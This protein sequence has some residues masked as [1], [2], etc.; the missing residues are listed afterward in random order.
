MITQL[1]I[2]PLLQIGCTRPADLPTPAPIVD[3]VTSATP[4][5]IPSGPP[6]ADWDRDVLS[7]ELE[8]D[9]LSHLA[10]ARITFAG[11]TSTSASLDVYDLDVIEITGPDGPISY[12]RRSDRLDLE[13]PSGE[14]PVTVSIRYAFDNQNN[15]V[16]WMPELGVTYLFPDNCGYFYPCRPD[17]AEGST[18]SLDVVGTGD[19]VAVYPEEI[20][21]DAPS[22]MLGMALGDYQQI[23]LGT[24]TAG[25]EVS[26]WHLPGSRDRML[27][28]AGALV[29][30]FD[31]YEQTYG[32]YMFGHRVASVEASW[33]G[34]Y[35][36]AE[37]HPYWHVS[38]SA[39]PDPEVHAHEAAHGW[40]GNG[41]R[42][43][44]WED[45]VMSDGVASYLAAHAVEELGLYDPWPAYGDWVDAVCSDPGS[46]TVAMPSGC[47]G[48]ANPDHPLWSA[49]P[50]VK[51]TCFLEDVGDL[52]GIDRLD[53]TLA[54]FYEEYRG[55]PAQVDHLLLIL[56]DLNRDHTAALDVLIEEWLTSEACP[57]DAAQR[58]GGHTP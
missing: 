53:E 37:H 4:T 46:N 33:G 2:L 10:T 18:F 11:S 41:V 58:C 42:L 5:E 21:A 15:F 43:N 36:G 13:L 50:Y 19:Q 14:D 7:T 35:G 12:L 57:V 25:T 52:I 30:I 3:P 56:K 1:S 38:D 32:P 8:L 44:C 39:L 20:P 54:A 27:D 47:S 24:T 31:F 34:N 40:F 28:G 29:E 45:L 16:G 6:E 51:G 55:R 48:A 26:A 17:P 49:V 22:Y 9:L 23:E